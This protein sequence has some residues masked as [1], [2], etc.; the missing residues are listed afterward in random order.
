M[1]KFKKIIAMCLSTMMTVAIVSMPAIAAPSDD[2]IVPY[3]HYGSKPTSQ[4]DLPFNDTM[5]GVNSDTGLG[6]SD[7]YFNCG[8]ACRVILDMS[9][10]NVQKKDAGA[11][12]TI[13]LKN[14]NNDTDIAEY[15]FKTDSNGDVIDP[16]KTVYFSTAQNFY[17]EIETE[18]GDVHFY[19][20]YRLTN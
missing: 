16:L 7:Y 10:V 2:S 8:E 17:L 14:W 15:E 20:Y 3:V 12:V 19:G 1:K 6:Y 5:Y 11:S 13:T 9:A 4:T 18:P